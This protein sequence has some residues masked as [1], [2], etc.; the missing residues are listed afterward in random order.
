MANDLPFDLSAL[1]IFPAVCE[2]GGMAPAARKHDITQPAI[3]Q[4]IGDIESRSDT[5]LFDRSVRPLALTATGAVLREQ[6][7]I[8]IAAVR[9]IASQLQEMQSG[10]VRQLRVGIV[11]SLS[12]ALTA[13]LSAFMK[14]RAERL[15]VHT[16]LTD[17]HA[18]AL[19]TRQLD[20]I[21]GEDDLEDVAGLERS[22]LTAVPGGH[23]RTPH[24]RGVRAG[25][26]HGSLRAFF[27]AL[28][29][30][31][32]GYS[33]TTRPAGTDARNRL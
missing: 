16:G 15:V 6:A 32:S 9:P 8:V 27:R 23:S 3:S 11:D 29:S 13:E 26:A 5:L 31:P 14:T 10:R 30:L 4:G 7:G 18:A 1:S 12:R 19:F 2:N 17:S 33:C 21:I 20:L 25:A 22:Q 24:A 28:A